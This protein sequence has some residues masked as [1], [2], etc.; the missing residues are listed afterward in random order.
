MS[1]A[2]QKRIFDPFYTTRLGKGGSGLGLHIVH[3]LT[4]GI[5]GGRI[6]VRSEPENGSEFLLH[7]PI[8]APSEGS[9]PGSDEHIA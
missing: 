9:Q 1:P 6:E 3:T 7:L 5:L 8:Q 4:T 2:T